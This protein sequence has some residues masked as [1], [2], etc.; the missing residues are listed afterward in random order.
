MKDHTPEPWQID[1]ELGTRTRICDA[2]GHL[3]AEVFRG[4]VTTAENSDGNAKR[5]VACV[6]FCTGFSIE[7]LTKPSPVAAPLEV[8]EN[9]VVQA[10][11][12][13][14]RIVGA[15]DPSVLEYPPVKQLLESWK[16]DL[17]LLAEYALITTNANKAMSASQAELAQ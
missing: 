6:N 8:T 7:T 2:E 17:R 14:K 4:F 5:I 13:V 12:R 1:L 16:N 9:N 3:V 11:E 10:A 15:W